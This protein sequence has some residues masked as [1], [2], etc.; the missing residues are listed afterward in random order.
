[1]LIKSKLKC[2]NF[3]LKHFVFGMARPADIRCKKMGCAVMLKYG[4][5]VVLRELNR[6]AINLGNTIIIICQQKQLD[7]WFCEQ[8]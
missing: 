8:I 4:A 2:I 6:D 7:L 5:L 3:G 1:M